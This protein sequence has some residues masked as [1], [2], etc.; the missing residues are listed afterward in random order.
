[1]F[2]IGTSDFPHEKSSYFTCC[3]NQHVTKA[4]IIIGVVQC[5]LSL[6]PVIVAIIISLEPPY[7]YSVS[8]WIILSVLQI[9]SVGLMIYGIRKHDECLIWPNAVFVVL[10]V[11]FFTS[12]L[13]SSIIYLAAYKYRPSYIGTFIISLILL[14][15]YV[16]FFMIISRCTNFARQKSFWIF[17][18]SGQQQRQLQQV[19]YAV[20][21]ANAPQQ[22]Y[23]N[24]MQPGFKQA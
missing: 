13:I 7:D 16:W 21:P 20:A 15:V 9:I 19:G 14:P 3:C 18:S 5:I 23:E 11:C 22:N 6:I 12:V 8:Y 10:M 4:A 2:T 17:H 1:M 24:S